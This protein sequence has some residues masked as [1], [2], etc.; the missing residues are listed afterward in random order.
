MKKF[1]HHEFPTLTRTTDASGSRVYEVPNGHVYPSV[2]SVI[3]LHKS[4]YLIE[5][6]EK[7]GEEEADRVSNRA[8]TRGTIIHK[9]CEDYLL[10]KEVSPGIF[11]AEMFN[12]IKP[13]LDHINNIHCLETYLYSDHLKVAGTVDIIAEY[14]NKLSIIDI[15][16]SL[17]AKNRDDIHNYFVQCAAYSV[18]FEERTGIGV[19]QLVIIMGVDNG[20]PLIFKEKRDTWIGEFKKLRAEYKRIKNI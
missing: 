13:H 9:L 20:P 17:R 10:G 8:A 18:A 19:S 5:W 1:I 11:D 4:D 7:V 3:G 12:S 14:Y 6:R 2:T 16:S 15:K